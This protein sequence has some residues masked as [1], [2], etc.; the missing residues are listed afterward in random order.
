MEELGYNPGMGLP[1]YEFT[2]LLLEPE[3]ARIVVSIGVD[4][5]GMVDLLDVIY[6]DAKKNGSDSLSFENM[7]D[8]ILNVRGANPATVKDVREQLRV[9]KQ[10]ITFTKDA[11]M[12]KIAEE[13]A[14]INMEIKALRDEALQ[15]DQDNAVLDDVEELT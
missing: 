15:R 7:V 4:I 6:E 13:F 9:T 12:N 8:I 2:K 1:Q 5:V 10:M 14:L 11:L 3:V